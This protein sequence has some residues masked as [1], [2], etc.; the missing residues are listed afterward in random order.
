MKCVFQLGFMLMLAL[1]SLTSLR[2]QSYEYETFQSGSYIIDMGVEPQTVGN[3]LKPYG[4]IYALT[5]EQKVPVKWVID[6]YKG[7]DSVDFTY[8]GYDFKGGPFVIPAQ[9]RSDAVDSLVASWVAQGVVITTTGSSISVPVAATINFFMGWTLDQDNG[10]IAQDYLTAAGIPS[11]AYNWL[12]PSELSCCNDV[13]VMP[14]A[15]PTW[16]THGNL[17]SWN[18]SYENGGCEGTIW[19]ACHAVSALENTFNPANPSQQMNFLSEKTGEAT[20]AGPY[21]DNSLVLW[22][23]HGDATPPN[24]Y[25]FS[26]HP[27]MQFLGDMD[28]ALNNGSEQIFIPHS[29]WRAST[30]VAGYDPNHP[31]ATSPQV[32]AVIAFGDAFGD[33][34]RG[35]VMYMGGHDHAKAFNADNIAAI[36]AMM[37][38]S[39]WAAAD[40]SIQLESDLEIDSLVIQHVPAT[41]EV[42]AAGGAGDFT[43]TWTSSCDGVFSHPDSSWTEFIPYNEGTCV[44]TC[45]VTDACGRVTY[46]TTAADVL[47]TDCFPVTGKDFMRGFIYKDNNGNGVEDL[48]EPYFDSVEVSVYLDSNANGTIDGLEG[49]APIATTETVDGYYEFVLDPR[50]GEVAEFSDQISTGNDDAFEKNTGDLD[51]S[52]SKIELKSDKLY[53]G[54]RFQGVTVPVGAVIDYAYLEFKASD[55]RPSAINLELSIEA[56]TSPAA[57][58]STKYNISQRWD[59]ANI[60]AWSSVESWYK[61]QWYQSPDIAQLVQSVV[62]ME[63]W[64][65]GK[66]MMLMVRYVSGH[67]RK[68]YS[69]NSGI[70]KAPRLVIGYRVP[71]YPTTFIAVVNEETLP[72]GS[73]ITTG[74]EVVSVFTREYQANCNKSF[75]FRI[76]STITVDD[77]NVT[78]EDMP[79]TG[80]VMRND[81]D[82]EGDAT[83][84]GGYFALTG[85]SAI[86]SGATVAGFDQNGGVVA[87]AG[88]LYF[89]ARGEYQ[90]V[91]SEGFAGHAA[92]NYLKCDNGNPAVCDT[93]KLTL[94]VNN[95][96][97][98][99]VKATNSV[100]ATNDF[101]IGYSSVV[102]GNFLEND[103]DP[104]MDEMDI[105]AFSFDSD[106]DG[107]ADSL[108]TA[109]GQPV[110]VA[111]VNRYGRPDAEAGTL[112][113]QAGGSFMFTPASGFAG[114]VSLAYSVCDDFEGAYKSCTDATVKI[115]IVE[116][117][118][119][120]ANKPPFAGDDYH[121]TFINVPVT[122]NWLVNDNDRDGDKI[123]VNATA[124]S[125][126][127]E[128]AGSGA[129]IGT[130]TTR[131]GGD[132]AFYDNGTYQYTPPADYYGP[133]Q[134]GYRICDVTASP[135][136]DSATI[137]LLAAPVYFDYG[138]L[139]AQ[140]P[141]AANMIP[142]DFDLDGTPDKPYSIWFGDIVDGEVA[143]QESYNADGDNGSFSN[144][145][146]GLI[147]PGYDRFM[148]WEYSTTELKVIVN[149]SDPGMT[150]YYGLW[151]DWDFDGEFDVFYNG[152]G[153][154][155]DWTQ[156][157]VDT[158]SVTVTVPFGGNDLVAGVR[159]RAFQSLPDASQ[160]GGN[161]RSGEVEDYTWVLSTLLP[162]ELSR[163][164]ATAQD[165]DALL[166]WETASEVNNEKFIVQRSR[167]AA[168]WTS[169][170][171]VA[172]H[173]NSS[174]VHNYAF[175]DA[176]LLSGKYYYRL[177]Q[178]DFDGASEYSDI[179]S[180]T[181]KGTND[182]AISEVRM[183]PVPVHASGTIYTQGLDESVREV[184]VYSANGS[185]SA[186]IPVVNGN[187]SLAGTE[188]PTGVYFLTFY[189]QGQTASKQITIYE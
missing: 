79:V 41:L 40:K 147:F 72:Y 133:D 56:N 67:E 161:L 90:F 85:G 86:S 32:A 100:V 15:D 103:S 134:L 163:F 91:P 141:K 165:N 39:F 128:N 57:L 30:Y 13:F 142:V 166:T 36:R 153:V 23:A 9:F 138:D 140:F 82:P 78:L 183:Y 178:V 115:R 75:G 116:N 88:T 8:N 18:D 48:D 162:V 64:E 74:N 180:V 2:G 120:T 49:L 187:I 154:T 19:A 95:F 157:N 131:K 156:R 94:V 70:S 175:T 1:T 35:K 158:L 53:A 132:V 69:Y 21:A 14:H 188:L 25:S 45:T 50:L 152:S 106:G 179:R 172:G 24:S 149:G 80:S 164:D 46:T 37:N 92:L 7:K 127:P 20:G 139:P 177:K 119:A 151:I 71:E 148:T 105:Q 58:V 3:A 44:I 4:L 189:Q 66:N 33:T 113:V 124:T 77:V 123:R 52:N 184:T 55:D 34:T 31:E 174:E 122:G 170:G 104:E 126:D 117:E 143:Y 47:P 76:N 81:F 171:E 185:Q 145:E 89:D 12:L 108:T 38:F 26:A 6:P 112:T 146:D 125:I 129:L 73:K 121:S 29:Q 109:F 155:A 43:Y 110:T 99:N 10:D 87:N 118:N 27:A 51:I 62:D 5:T 97:N 59:A 186:T 68:A 60:V 28:D 54:L 160:F 102:K 114:E 65:G 176:D 61:D 136:C 182:R 130:F 96:P 11:S 111:G 98:P 167:D 16:A 83:S 22:D 42:F 159:L 107:E 181:I 144:D 93:G 150:V 168:N 135:A 101:Q 173:G 137:Y 169:I 63:S 84:F 17:L